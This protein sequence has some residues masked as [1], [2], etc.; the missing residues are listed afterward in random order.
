VNEVEIPRKDKTDHDNPFKGEEGSNSTMEKTN[1]SKQNN[2][3]SAIHTL[4]TLH[5]KNE[6]INIRM[7]KSFHEAFMRYC[8]LTG[9][10]AGR[11]YE[12]AG[13]LFMDIN[14]IDGVMIVV[15]NTENG[16]VQT[17]IEDKMTEIII[18]GE[19][20]EWLEIVRPLV[21]QGVELHKSKIKSLRQIVRET[22]NLNTRSDKLN[23]LLQEALEYAI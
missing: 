18:I 8:N 14:P 1:T 7:R 19:L 16:S 15:E 3:C 22:K 23:Q 5:G 20:E 4:H 13:L 10:K 17:S 2:L 21:N 11:F 6:P 9:M 12:Q